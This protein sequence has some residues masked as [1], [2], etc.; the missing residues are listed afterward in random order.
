MI[1]FIAVGLVVAAGTG[2]AIASRSGPTTV[3]TGEL[4]VVSQ[5]QPDPLIDQRTMGADEAPITIY[6]ASDF[7]CPYCRVF[8][9]ETLPKIKQEYIETGKARMIFLNFPIPQLHANAAAAHEFAR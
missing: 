9:E 5:G 2:W 4:G 8:W 1:S 3:P 6:E 7:Q